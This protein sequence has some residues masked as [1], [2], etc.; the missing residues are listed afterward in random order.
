MDYGMNK[1]SKHDKAERDEADI[2]YRTT[3]RSDAAKESGKLSDD[4]E[5]E[6]WE[7]YSCS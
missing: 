6:E 5:M 3:V 2:E 4:E 1:K 7:R